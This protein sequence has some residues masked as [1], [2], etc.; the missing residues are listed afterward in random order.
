MSVGQPSTPELSL[1]ADAKIATRS[2]DV[3]SSARRAMKVGEGRELH[4]EAAFVLELAG[5]LIEPD[6]IADEDFGL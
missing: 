4:E 6:A 2:A 5:L 3:R 1:R